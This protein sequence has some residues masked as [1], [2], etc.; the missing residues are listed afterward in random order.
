M[1]LSNI[2]IQ[3]FRQL[4]DQLVT[5]ATV[6]HVNAQ[7]AHAYLF[8]RP[9][10]IFIP[11]DSDLA[12][13]ISYLRHII[14]SQGLDNLDDLLFYFEKKSKKID[15]FL[16]QLVANYEEQPNELPALNEDWLYPERSSGRLSHLF[17]TKAN[18][19]VNYISNMNDLKNAYSR[20]SHELDAKTEKPGKCRL[21]KYSLPKN[22]ESGNLYI[23]HFSEYE[24]LG[25]VFVMKFAFRQKYLEIG[26][27]SQKTTLAEWIIQYFN[28]RESPDY[29]MII[30]VIR[31]EQ[32]IKD[33]NF[34]FLLFEWLIFSKV[35]ISGCGTTTED[36]AKA[37]VLADIG[38]YPALKNQQLCYYS[39]HGFRG[40]ITNLFEAK[41]ISKKWRILKRSA[42]LFW[43]TSDNPG[44]L[45]HIGEM[46]AGKKEAQ[47]V[48]SITEIRLDTV[49]Y[50]PLSKDYCLRIEPNAAIEREGDTDDSTI[51]YEQSSKEEVDF[52]NMQTIFTHRDVVIAPQRKMLSKYIS[53]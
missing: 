39:G 50:Y 42:D 7:C 21:F 53:V 24:K 17:V 30:N 25:Y 15:F 34:K 45:I 46:K 11:I 2:Q 43:L 52:V 29:E 14:V 10:N 27:I 12:L 22:E 19:L 5:P 32:P 51:E 4:L 40:W 35:I 20:I 9:I 13:A 33:R 26:E 41:L 28:A 49:L 44:F 48:H 18:Q 31:K 37:D 6:S 1:S 38:Y 3:S 36:T 23:G 8:E 47:L 16:E